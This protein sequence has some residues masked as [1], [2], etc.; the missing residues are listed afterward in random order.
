MIDRFTTLII[1]QRAFACERQQKQENDNIVT[2]KLLDTDKSYKWMLKNKILSSYL[3]NE[4][5]ITVIYV[6]RQQPTYYCTKAIE[7][8]LSQTRPQDIYNTLMKLRLG[9]TPGP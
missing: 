9:S 6:S 2:I 4:L 5:F 8:Y 1:F 3:E 7:F